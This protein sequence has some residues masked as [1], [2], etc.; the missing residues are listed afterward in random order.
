[1]RKILCTAV[2]LGFV[3]C[4]VV[5][6]MAQTEP[7]VDVQKSIQEIM[8]QQHLEK[9]KKTLES[10]EW[11]VYVTLEDSKRPKTEEDVFTFKD[12]TIASRN[13]LAKGYGPSNFSLNVQEDG[14]AIWETM[15]VKEN[16]GTIFFRGEL[17]GDGNMR[18]AMGTKPKKGTRASYWFTTIRPDNYAVSV[19]A[20]EKVSAEEEVI[21]QGEEAA[22][23]AKKKKKGKK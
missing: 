15:Q 23:P 6:V 5:P 2:V 9:G 16:E 21:A 10:K 18:G 1:M 22:K 8:R 19:P 14:I 20:V 4:M 17:L 12:G 7:Q 11:V 13:L 3:V